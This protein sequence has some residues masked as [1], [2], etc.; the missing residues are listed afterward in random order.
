MLCLLP[1][2]ACGELFIGEARPADWESRDLL[3]LTVLPTYQSDCML[4][5]CGGEK[6]FIDGARDTWHDEVAAALELLDATHMDYLFSSHPHPD[7]LE[8]ML[9]LLESGAMNGAV[10]TSGT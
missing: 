5:E 3:R 4:L 7:H 2:T 6:M 8:N 9:A 10:T 1:F